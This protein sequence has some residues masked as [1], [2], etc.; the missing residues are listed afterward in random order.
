MIIMK[1]IWGNRKYGKITN[2]ICNIKKV[3]RQ[4]P[5]QHENKNK[6]TNTKT[7]PVEFLVQIFS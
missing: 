2:K 3:N 1:K 6:N 4:Y 5:H 7:M